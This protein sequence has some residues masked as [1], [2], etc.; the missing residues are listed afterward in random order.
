MG[1]TG[2]A[3]ANDHSYFYNPA[4]LAFSAYELTL[5]AAAAFI[6]NTHAPGRYDEQVFSL[7]VSGI[8]TD[9]NSTLG[10]AFWWPHMD[11]TGFP[12]LD[13]YGNPTGGTFGWQND[14][15][16]LTAAF[17]LHYSVDIAMGE[18]IKYF[19]EEFIVQTVDGPVAD[20]GFALRSPMSEDATDILRGK[21]S[22]SYLIGL[23]GG[24]L[25]NI[26][27]DIAYYSGDFPP[28]CTWRIG[29]SVEWGIIN[30]EPYRA[31]K[32]VS[33][34]ATF[35]IEDDFE[36]SERSPFMKYG[37]EAGLYEAALLRFGVQSRDEI[38]TW[39]FTF[40]SHGI[41]RF[42]DTWLGITASSLRYLADHIAVEYSYAE[43]HDQ[44]EREFT[45][46]AYHELL[47]T[48]WP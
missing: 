27:P 24:A 39:G 13:Y 36:E 34:M 33:L 20:L 32:Q 8:A 41:M 19:R 29:S 6:D 17:A 7:S 46:P 15:Y 37:F 10:I 35:E 38:L 43:Y 3:L 45:Y 42:L 18:T 4:T 21:R 40:G 23:L 14:F 48:W 47:L 1:Q 44:S 2:V 16:A 30:S 11:A 12:I 25:I 31:W 28:P 22:G 9:K 26:G 5:N